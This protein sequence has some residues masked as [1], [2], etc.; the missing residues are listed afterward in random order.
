MKSTSLLVAGLFLGALLMYLFSGRGGDGDGRKTAKLEAEITSLQARIAE[1]EKPGKK[2]K[3]ESPG[4]GN[5]VKVVR[6]QPAEKNIKEAVDGAV[7]RALDVTGNDN[8]KKAMREQQDRLRKNRVASELNRM[9]GPLGLNDA[10]EE[11]IGELVGR[12]RQSSGIITFEGAEPDDSISKAEVD[13]GI[14][15]LL[16][17]D[18]L[19]AFDTMR[20]AD[21]E[22][23]IEAK[24]NSELAGLQ[25]TLNLTEEQK[26]AAF[27]VLTEYATREIDKPK[28]GIDDNQGWMNRRQQK[29]EALSEVLT[30]EQLEIYK[31]T[32]QVI[33][34]TLVDGWSTNS[35][36]IGSSSGG[37]MRD[38]SDA[39]AGVTIQGV[40]LRMEEAVE[41]PAGSAEN[42]SQP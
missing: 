28:G 12:M 38:D 39:E 33:T 36:M 31:S 17:D 42:P 21:R 26:D 35:I 25:R 32:P 20:D 5:P 29:M 24:A 13:E 1:L 2:A 8:W 3:A 40:E 30:P 10:Q 34:T 6:N 27:E 37:L 23:A 7:G 22:N 41:I 16:N 15:E 14:R 4:A 9:R 11:A 18:Q 19:A